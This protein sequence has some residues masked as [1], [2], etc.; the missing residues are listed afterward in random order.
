[1]FDV[2]KVEKQARLELAEEQATEAKAKVKSLLKKI[3]ASKKV[4]QNLEYELEVLM[5]DIGS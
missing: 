2:K 1:M 4:T 3:D 5:Q